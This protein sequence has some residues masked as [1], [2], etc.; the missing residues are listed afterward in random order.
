MMICLIVTPTSNHLDIDSAILR[1]ARADKWQRLVLM[2]AKP[3]GICTTNS[4]TAVQ[5]FAAFQQHMV[6]RM[7]TCMY[8]VASD[9]KGRL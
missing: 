6:E 9:D 3:H 8:M 7:S 5:I 1:C 2:H 4:A